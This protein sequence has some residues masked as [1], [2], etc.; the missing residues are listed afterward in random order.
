M[1]EGH[2][3]V[4]DAAAA[5]TKKALDGKVLSS[6]TSINKERGHSDLENGKKRKKAH[7]ICLKG[8]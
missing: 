4:T 5:V 3:L 2:H 6:G 1:I 8:R 7:K